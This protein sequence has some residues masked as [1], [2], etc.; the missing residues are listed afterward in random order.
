MDI[1]KFITENAIWLIIFGVLIVMAMI[2]YMAEKKN[3]KEKKSVPEP[4]PK[5]KEQPIE[6][7]EPVVQKKE[8][9]QPTTNVVNDILGM[10]MNAAVSQTPAPTVEMP[11][12]TSQEIKVEAAPETVTA[13][14]EDLTVPLES[15]SALSSTEQAI[16]LESIPV[17]SSE[18]EIQTITSKANSPMNATEATTT[19]NDFAIN[20]ISTLFGETKPEESD[21][22]TDV[23]K[24]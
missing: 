7:E 20:D 4:V 17:V 12:E 10:D 9:V 22:S 21:S 3:G 18:P 15:A 23:W 1:T 5:E 24:F 13:T 19:N 6:K 16:N 14:G 2:G 8:P 11:T